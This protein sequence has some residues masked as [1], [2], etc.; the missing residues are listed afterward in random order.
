MYDIE[1]SLNEQILG[2]AGDRPTV[3]FAEATDPRQIEAVCSLT[4][5][6][7]PVFLASER[8][9]REVIRKNLG[10]IDPHRVEYAMSETA[11]VDI[12]TRKD[13]LAEFAASYKG[14]CSEGGHPVTVKAAAEAVRK[15]CLFGIMAVRGGHA[16]MVVGGSAH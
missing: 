3:V 11:F 4:R 13:L 12:D 15:S 14:I 7:R 5:F 6:I 16:D 1:K 10:H 9:V 2:F 8:E